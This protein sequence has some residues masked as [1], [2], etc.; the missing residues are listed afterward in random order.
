M[1]SHLIRQD[2]I[3]RYHSTGFTLI[4]LMITVAIM[5]IILA[6]AVPSF[7]KMIEQERIITA[8]ESISSDLVLARNES[9]RT[10]EASYFTLETGWKYSVCN[11]NGAASCTCNST[12]PLNAT[13]G[14][15]KRRF[16]KESSDWS[17]ISANTAAF[18]N[19][20]KF[21]PINGMPR[22]LDNSKWTGSG[23]KSL[24]LSSSLG[25]ELFITIGS[26][27]R[28]KVCTNSTSTKKVGRY[29]AV[30][31]GGDCL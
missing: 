2:L 25:Q 5:A 16:T 11:A 27:G 29:T 1:Q 31:T 3:M 9:I 8:A 30:S 12:T 7:N 6:V 18:D 19:D 17:N 23:K 26:S 10:N 28:V 14:S 22:E 4:E 21:D 20:F 24:T 15:C 13:K